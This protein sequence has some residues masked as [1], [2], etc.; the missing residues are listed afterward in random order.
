MGPNSERDLLWEW[1]P[2]SWPAVWVGAQFRRPTWEWDPWPNL[3]IR[4]P[5]GGALGRLG[6][7]LRGVGTLTL[8]YQDPAG[9]LSNLH[10]SVTGAGDLVF[11]NAQ[12]VSGDFFRQIRLG[13][14]IGSFQFGQC[15]GQVCGSFSVDT[16]TFT[17]LS[18][19]P[20]PIAGAGLEKT[21]KSWRHE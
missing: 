3:K 6:I 19:V 14:T 9:P 7:R 16:L 13:T 18:A 10:W 12:V 2:N 11:G 21:A 17:N 20:G 15:P 4:K 8:N 1:D 5:A